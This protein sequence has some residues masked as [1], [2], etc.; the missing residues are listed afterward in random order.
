MA[1][2]CLSSGS[3]FGMQAL[4]KK[5]MAVAD[6]QSRAISLEPK[7]EQDIK[8]A[9]LGVRKELGFRSLIILF[10]PKNDDKYR[11]DGCR[12]GGAL[13]YDFDGAIQGN[14]P[15]LTSWSFL[16]YALNCE[17]TKK[18]LEKWNI[19]SVNIEKGNDFYQSMCIF[20]PKK[21]E[22]YLKKLGKYTVNS[23]YQQ[24]SDGALLLG[25]NL[26]LG[27]NTMRV[28]GYSSD[29]HAPLEDLKACLNQ[30]L[31]TNADLKKAGI[32]E[33]YTNTWDIYLSGHG[34]SK[35]AGYEQSKIA[36]VPIEDFEKFLEFLNLGIST[37]SLF[38]SSCFSGGENLEKAYEYG[39]GIQLA[40]EEKRSK[41]FNYMI[42]SANAF[43]T[44]TSAQ[45][46]E[47]DSF[48]KYFDRLGR[49][50]TR[51]GY[52]TVLDENTKNTIPLTLDRVINT[53]YA[54]EYSFDRA[55]F[56]RAHFSS[57]KVRL[58]LPTV[59]LAHADRFVLTS[60]DDKRLFVINDGTI[61]SVING[62][63]KE[64]IIPKDTKMIVLQSRYIPIPIVIQGYPSDPSWL[65]LDPTNLSNYKP[66]MPLIVPQEPDKDYFIKEIRAEK[67]YLGYGEAGLQSALSSLNHKIDNSLLKGTWYIEKLR[68]NIG[69]ADLL[70]NLQKG[71]STTIFN[72]KGVILNLS[73]QYMIF[74]LPGEE[75]NMVYDDFTP[76]ERR[77]NKKDAFIYP[78][79]DWLTQPHASFINEENKRIRIARRGYINNV[80][81]LLKDKEAKM[82][83]AISKIR[84]E[85]KLPESMKIEEPKAVVTLPV[86]KK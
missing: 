14:V 49:Y 54:W 32:D 38:Y 84:Q 59:R 33:S 81:E 18:H 82:A 15:I 83:A 2:I 1:M 10:D 17:D 28:E 47:S 35:A 22:D 57:S 40:Q 80:P 70:L 79:N 46:L 50:L 44:T 55:N 4:K 20:I 30:I 6:M 52:Q 31:V 62:N 65:Q 71:F 37:R 72:L 41:D 74:R 66:T 76:Q 73:E 25:M 7:T 43:G 42:I 5:Q 53:I 63:K 48:D 51:T 3:A 58:E 60:S 16:H 23:N 11:F 86:K 9:K 12:S 78:Y 27:I 34:S 85:S 45:K 75:F 69:E 21:N 29:N 61:E 36:A 8:A 13:T 26:K 56:V 68:I 67:C 24:I 19:Y 77:W 64:I 39:T